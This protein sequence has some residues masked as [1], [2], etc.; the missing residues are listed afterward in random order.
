MKAINAKHVLFKDIPNTPYLNMSSKQ[1]S[2]VAP[3]LMKKEKD[4][5]S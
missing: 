3:Y 2:N 1:K 5:I 4:M